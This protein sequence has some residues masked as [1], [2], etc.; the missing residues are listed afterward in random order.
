M[1]QENDCISSTLQCQ[2]LY[3]LP[4][5]VWLTF[6]CSLGVERRSHNCKGCSFWW[7]QCLQSD[8]YHQCM[9]TLL[10]P[11]A[12]ALCSPLRP[13]LSIV[14]R[15]KRRQPYLDKPELLG[16]FLH[17]SWAGVPRSHLLLKTRSC[18]RCYREV[19]E[20]L[21][22]HF[23]ELQYSTEHT[24]PLQHCMKIEWEAASCA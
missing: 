3:I 6:F 13:V 19:G 2:C 9:H 1:T 22:M 16:K 4:D 5:R 21:F 15:E 8:S 23:K 14:D 17:A 18:W 11:V 7:W 24:M 12:L 10:P 20:K